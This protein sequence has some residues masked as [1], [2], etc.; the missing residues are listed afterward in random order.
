MTV[1]CFRFFWVGLSDFRVILLS[2]TEAGASR[3][4]RGVGGGFKMLVQEV[5]LLRVGINFYT[6]A[7]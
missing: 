6:K 5:D 3:G 1:L 2:V 7:T 4:R